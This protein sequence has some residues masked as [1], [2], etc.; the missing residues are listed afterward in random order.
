MHKL[1]TLIDAYLAALI[2]VNIRLFE[3]SYELPVS[4]PVAKYLI[5]CVREDI[6][7]EGDVVKIRGKLLSRGLALGCFY[8]IL[9]VF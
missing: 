2:K 8:G 3:D 1:H 6:V 7:I 5:G 4:L 9:A